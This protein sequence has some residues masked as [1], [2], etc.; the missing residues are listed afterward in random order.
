MSNG[1]GVERRKK[2][3]IEE[4]IQRAE[5]NSSVSWVIIVAFPSAPSA[6]ANQWNAN[7]NNKK[8]KEE[9][10]KKKEPTK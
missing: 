2:T 10:N 6:K 1:L 3:Q 5:L 7:T 4:T 9:N 8:E